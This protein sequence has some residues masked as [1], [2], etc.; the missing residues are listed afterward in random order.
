MIACLSVQIALSPELTA[1]CVFAIDAISCSNT[2]IGMRRIDMS[3]IAYLFVLYLQSINPNIKCCLLFMIEN[4]SGMGNERIQAQINEILAL[5]QSL[6][7]RGFITSDGESSY[8]QRHKTF[9]DFWEPIYQGFGLD[10][11]LAGLKQYPHVMPLSNLLHLGKNFRIQFL[12][13]ELTFVYGGASSSISQER[14]VRFSIWLFP[15][16]IRVS[17]GKCETHI[18]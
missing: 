12:K 16:Q 17:S 11:I 9:M 15:C 4:P 6:I 14:S 13:Y 3:D 10:R 2:F 5:T 8:Y 18:P 7:P 1:V